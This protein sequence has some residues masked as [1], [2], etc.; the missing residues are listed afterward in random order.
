MGSQRAGNLCVLRIQKTVLGHDNSFN[1]ET[2]VQTGMSCLDG[3]GPGVSQP[4][5]T[6]RDSLQLSGSRGQVSPDLSQEPNEQALRAHYGK[7][8]TMFQSALPPDL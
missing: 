2:K 1:P 7:T 6:P 8:N 5:K 4:C 3:S